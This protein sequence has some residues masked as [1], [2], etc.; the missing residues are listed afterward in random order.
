MKEQSWTVYADCGIL[1]GS[2]G[3]MAGPA[4]WHFRASRVGCPNG[5]TQRHKTKMKEQ[6]WTVHTDCGI[7]RGSRGRMAGSPPWHFRASRVGGPNGSTQRHTTKNEG[8]K[9]DRP[10]RLPNLAWFT[11]RDGRTCTLAFPRQPGGRLEW[12]HSKAQDKNQGT[13][14]DRPRRLRNPKRHPDLSRTLAGVHG[15][16]VTACN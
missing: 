9:L 6:S 7:L 11:W 13:K 8:T 10:H 3:R 4:P 2:R 14:L 16:N 1:R 12:E 15:L 5:S